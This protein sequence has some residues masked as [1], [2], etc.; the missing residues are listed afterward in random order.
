MTATNLTDTDR[1]TIISVDGHAGADMRAYKPYLASRWYDE[2]DAWADAYVNPFAD[3]L[4]PTAYRNWDGERRLKET[5]SNGIV[6]EVLFPNTVPPFF[7]QGNLTALEPTADD[8][9][10][11]WAGVQAHNRWLADFCAQAPGRRAGCAQVF[12]NDLDDTLAEIR[13]AK[14]NMHVFG[15]ILMPNVAPNSSLPPLW[16]PHYEP[17]W[18][19]CEELDVV[20]NVHTGTGLPDFGEQEAA[21]AILLIEIAWFAHRPVWHLIFGGVVE[22]HPALRV[23]LTEQGTS[24]IP[25]GVDTLDWFHR[26]MTHGGA[27]EAMFFGAVTKDMSMTPSEYFQRNFWVGASFLRPSESELRYE[28]GIDRIMWG[29]DYPHSEGSYPYTTEAL[30][31]AFAPCPPAETKQMLETNA[32]G[33]YGF[34]LDALREI[35]DRIGPTVAEV[36]VPLDPSEYPADSTC[37]AFDHEQVIKAW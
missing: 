11:R 25:R 4:A 17:L 13:W 32:A 9:E 34:D 5:E 20:C 8:Y 3:L 28:V 33:V 1:Y 35:G 18:N 16:D 14:E 24:W 37:N 31:A 27:A 19:L 10:R 6:A 22:R 21:R 12:L 36:Q 15:G 26:R 7:A 29:A 30:R 23:V 2:F